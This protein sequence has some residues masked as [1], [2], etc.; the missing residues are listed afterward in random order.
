LEGLASAA[1][2]ASVLLVVLDSSFTAFGTGAL[3]TVS[4]LST[5]DGDEAGISRPAGALPNPAHE[6]KNTTDTATA[7]NMKRFIETSC[8]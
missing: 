6:M 1:T 7:Q 2:S 5:V 8:D 4:L 3:R